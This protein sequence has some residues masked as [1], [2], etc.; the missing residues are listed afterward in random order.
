[1]C[2]ETPKPWWVSKTFWV[3]VL[4]ALIGLLSFL[5]EMP[6]MA[7]VPWLSSAILFLAG[8]LMIILRFLTNKAVTPIFRLRRKPKP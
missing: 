1:M 2:S 5:N 6:F 4:T 7:A 8:I 3:G